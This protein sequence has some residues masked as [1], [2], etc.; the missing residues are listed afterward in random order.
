MA[1]D[2]FELEL[3][4]QYADD[5]SYLEMEN[6]MLKKRIWALEAQLERGEAPLCD[7]VPANDNDY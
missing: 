4:R 5:H 7:T 1:E 3:R 6:S 2:A